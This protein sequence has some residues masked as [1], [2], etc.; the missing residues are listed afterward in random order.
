MHSSP[1]PT[2]AWWHKGF[3]PHLEGVAVCE[4]ADSGRAVLGDG[5]T[6]PLALLR[7]PALHHNLEV[8]RDFCRAS[9]VD[10]APHGKTTMSPRLIS[11]QL[12]HGAWAITAATPWQVR[13]L[14]HHGVSRILLA[15]ELVDPGAVRWVA[16]QLHADPGFAFLCYVDSVDGV[17]VM[18]EALAATPGRTRLDVLLEVGV[19][20]GRTGC[21]D[22]A[23]AAAVA[24][25][26]ARSPRLRLR[27][28]AGFEGI[29]G[30][31]R[32]AGTLDHVDRFLG[33]VRALTEQLLAQHRFDGE[34]IVTAGGSA[35]FDRVVTAL[36]QGWPA[37]PPVRVVLRSGC[38]LTHDHGA[39]DAVTPFAGATALQPALEVWG[40]VLSRPEPTLAIVDVGKRDVSHDAG[41]PTPLHVWRRGATSPATAEGWQTTALN[42]QHASVHLPEPSA[43]AVSDLVGF[44]IS[45]PCTTFD[46]WR[47][48][49][50]VDDDYRM[51]DLVDTVF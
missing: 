29:L 33:R 3:A 43:V 18:T 16:E 17:R 2:V 50:V 15:N 35:F 31:D 25:A 20:G 32:S 38:Y 39:Y 8:M 42:D 51:V 40:R 34:V 37:R 28:V 4:L 12:Q 5:T 21:R 26:V 10:L 19:L 22:E 11:L 9:G 14:R 30:G 23:D 7:G 48:L 6:T 27:G 1:S 36:A 13:V 47:L 41:L 45:H 46:K 24:D 44:G 49:P